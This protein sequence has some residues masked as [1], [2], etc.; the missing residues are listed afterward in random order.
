MIN[1]VWKNIDKICVQ[2]RIS[3]EELASILQT[4]VHSLRQSRNNNA[5]LRLD[6]ALLF[7]RKFNVCIEQLVGDDVDATIASQYYAGVK[8]ELPSRY[9]FAAFSKFRS[10]I[11]LFEG[12][13][14]QRGEEYLQNLLRASQTPRELFDDP[15]KTIN[16]LFLSDFLALLQ[17]R[18]WREEDIFRLGQHSAVTN[19]TSPMGKILGAERSWQDLYAKLVEDFGQAFDRNYHYRLLSLTRDEALIEAIPN[20]EVVDGFQRRNFDTELTCVSRMGVISS[21]ANYLRLPSSVVTKIRSIHAGS[22]TNV[23]YVQRANSPLHH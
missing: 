1:H 6:E 5:V 7:S 20:Q 3:E 9:T 22:S 16:V 15:D 11:N 14:A 4:T 12:I 19:Q 2:S 18:G 23:Y 10:L 17:R 13:K 21:V 8:Q